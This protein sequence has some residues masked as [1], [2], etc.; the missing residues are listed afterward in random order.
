MS[1]N[2]VV[3]LSHFNGSVDLSAAAQSGIVGVIH[4]ATQGTR[5]QDPMYETNKAKAAAANL[6]WGAY[7]FGDGSEGVEQAEAFLAFVKPTKGTL[8]VLDFEANPQGPSMDLE[9]A[10]AFV[11]HVQSV[12]GRWP[13]LYAGY[14]LKQL[15]GT[16]S[17][18]VLRNC[19]LWLAQ[20][21][22]TAV[23]PHNWPAWTMWQYTDGAAGPPPY[24]V[25]GI[26]RCDRDMFNGTEA[27][28][29]QLWHAP[30]TMA[31]AGS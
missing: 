22:P 13:G 21:G 25:P 24:E 5:Y 15:L 17:D 10:R 3:D 8:L 14:Y 2:V 31:A 11:T 26:G 7:H 16:K 18:P 30:A 12:T 19:W 1:V 27:E 23:V 29:R 4:K 6:L 9:E 20:Y 28:L